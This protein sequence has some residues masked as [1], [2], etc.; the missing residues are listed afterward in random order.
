M[1]SIFKDL[2]KFAKKWNWLDIIAIFFARILPYV[3][4]ISLIIFGIFTKSW[5]IIIYPFLS[6]LVARFIVNSPI[7]FFYKRVRPA[8]LRDTNLLIPI[9]KNPSFPS[10]HASVFSAISFTIL[11]FNITLGIIFLSL[12]IL[13]GIARVFC[14]VHWFR[15]ILGGFISGIFSSLIIYYLINLI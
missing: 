5:E 7:Y 11:Y 15:D 9:P 13:I 3:L 2:N 14:G 12:S 10:S 4:I 8:Y 1:I 6:A